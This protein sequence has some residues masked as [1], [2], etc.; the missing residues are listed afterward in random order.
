MVTTRTKSLRLMEGEERQ[1]AAVISSIAD[2]D[3]NTEAAST[4]Q[5]VVTPRKILG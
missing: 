1:L 4:E 2:T 3:P 5:R